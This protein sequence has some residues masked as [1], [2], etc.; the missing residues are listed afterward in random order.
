MLLSKNE[1]SSIK[2]D[3][4]E[5]AFFQATGNAV[6]KRKIYKAKVVIQSSAIIND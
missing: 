1:G 2:K 4:F 6:R 5:E 3:N